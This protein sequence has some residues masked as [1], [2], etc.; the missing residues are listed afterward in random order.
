MRHS[1]LK[2]LVIP[3]AR[4]ALSLLLLAISITQA[5]L[6]QPMWLEMVAQLIEVGQSAADLVA[7]MANLFRNKG[8][9]SSS[10]HNEDEKPHA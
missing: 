4:L 1:R 3:I 9:G 2:A 6:G 7:G 8:G 5:C 10:P